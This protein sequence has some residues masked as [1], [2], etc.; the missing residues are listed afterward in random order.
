LKTENLKRRALA[1]ALET[2]V[3]EES[4]SREELSLETLLP[5]TIPSATGNGQPQS[6]V[7]VIL[8]LREDLA[9]FQKAS[10]KQ[11]FKETLRKELREACKE[12]L[13]QGAAGAGYPDGSS[14]PNIEL[15][16]E[17]L[18]ERG[19]IRP[20]LSRARRRRLEAA[21]AASEKTSEGSET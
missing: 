5:E 8:G 7:D 2:T 15:I 21:L 13:Q 3:L 14:Y 17:Y 6:P 9:K 4:T 20:K 16:V 18:R 1:M 10:S 12:A 19:A 11:A